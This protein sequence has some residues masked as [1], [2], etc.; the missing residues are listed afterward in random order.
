MERL[1]KF[2]AEAGVASRRAC[3]ELI[4]QGRVT[5]NGEKVADIKASFAKDTF[6]DEFIL[7]RGKKNFMKITL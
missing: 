2:M 3:E 4:R 7:K 6:K 1:Q 5:V